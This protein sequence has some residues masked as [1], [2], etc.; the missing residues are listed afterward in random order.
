[1]KFRYKDYFKA[2]PST[3]YETLIYDCMIGDNILFQRADSVEAGWRAVQP[4]LD[5][6]KNAGGKGL[7]IYEAGSEGP[8]EADAS[9]SATAAAGESSVKPMT[10]SDHRQCD[11]GCRSG[12]AGE[13]RRGARHGA[14]SGQSRPRGDLPDRRLEPEAALSNCS[15]P[16]PIE[17]GSHGSA[18]TGSSATNASC[19]RTIRS[20][21]WAWRGAIFLDRCAPAANI[22]P[23]P[24]RRRPADPDRSR[25][26]YE[27]EL[28]SFYGADTSRPGPAAVRPRADGRRPRRPYRVAVSR[29]SGASKKPSAGWSASPRPMSSPSCRA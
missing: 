25:R 29:L 16:M 14:D 6:W 22:H 7:K 20:T 8:E 9:S 12:R 28:K 15:R 27:Q 18:C 10:P 5:A 13:G 17:A 3:G 26:T 21:I 4:F 23:I 2:E 11:R 24:T 19:R 1:M